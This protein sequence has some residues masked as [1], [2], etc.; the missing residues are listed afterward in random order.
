MITL[1]ILI[2]IYT[3]WSYYQSYKDDYD[4]SLG[5]NLIIYLGLVVGTVYCLIVI[6]F[7]LITYLP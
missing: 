3:I 5:K 4:T 1:T 6:C 2:F 7:L